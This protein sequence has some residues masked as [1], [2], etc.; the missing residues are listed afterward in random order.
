VGRWERGENHPQPYHCQRLGEL[1]EKTVEELGLVKEVHADWGEAPHVMH[2][3]GRGRERAFLEHWIV[4]DKSQV[5][6]VL[7]AG[8]IGKTAL[9]KIV[10][11]KI[12]QR[13]DYVFWRSLK[14]A[15]PLK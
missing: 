11:E 8:A 5:V 1:Y 10:A 3:Y 2:L 15:P 6:A 7:G 14:N 13:F 4:D 12:Q 9:T